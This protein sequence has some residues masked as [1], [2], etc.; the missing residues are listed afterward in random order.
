MHCSMRGVTLPW[1]ALASSWLGVDDIVVGVVVVDGGGVV[2]GSG[3]RK[4]RV[5]GAGCWMRAGVRGGLGINREDFVFVSAVLVLPQHVCMRCSPCVVCHVC[6]ASF[7]GEFAVH[8]TSIAHLPC[9]RVAS[10]QYTYRYELV[11]Y[12]A[13][14]HLELVIAPCHEALCDTAWA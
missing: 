5:M 4:V 10:Q 8:T 2:L 3:L 14:R 1:F 9:L 11:S 6:H 12:H 7:T 13:C